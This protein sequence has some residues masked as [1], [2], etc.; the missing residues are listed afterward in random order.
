MCTRGDGVPG[1]VGEALAVLGSALDFL[2]GPAG[3]AVDP[4]AL[5]SVLQELAGIDSRYAAARMRFIARFD[6]NGCHDADGYQ[7]TGAWLAG[8]TRMVPGKAKAEARQAR[9]LAP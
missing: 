2:N 3:E 7:S 6:A 9:Q 4:A 5:G 8:K 1:S